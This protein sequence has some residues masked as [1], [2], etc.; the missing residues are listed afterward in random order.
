[1]HIVQLCIYVLTSTEYEVNILWQEVTDTVIYLC[2][3][4]SLEVILVFFLWA[5]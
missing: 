2:G 1:M 3:N 4:K 5:E